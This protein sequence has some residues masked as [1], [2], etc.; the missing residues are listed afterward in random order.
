MED[1]VPV[2]D[3]K[4]K[5]SHD[6]RWAFKQLLS[7]ADHELASTSKE[8]EEDAST[9][10]ISEIKDLL[11]KRKPTK[12]EQR[13]IDEIIFKLDTIVFKHIS[14]YLTI[15]LFA[16]MIVIY[17]SINFQHFLR[18][19][20]IAKKFTTPHRRLYVFV[21]ENCHA[22][23]HSYVIVNSICLITTKT[24]YCKWS[25]SMF[26]FLTYSHYFD[27]LSCKLCNTRF[28][29]RILLDQHN[30]DVHGLPSTMQL[31]CPEPDCPKRFQTALSLRQHTKT[32]LKDLPDELMIPCPE[33]DKK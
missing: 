12:A 8:E 11:K 33:C 24:S 17:A 2:V 29:R 1:E 26:F 4:G 27:L 25:S 23:V 7:L 21:T 22:E 31:T 16:D 10:S 28:T 5:Y 20:I 13:K 18:S 6:D 14:L 30:Q 19:L 15:S 9:D 3:E 32:H